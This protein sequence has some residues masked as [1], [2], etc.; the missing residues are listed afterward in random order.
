MQ[1]LCQ[2]LGAIGCG[3]QPRAGMR[4]TF[5][6]A[7]AT[8]TS[9]AQR[10]QPAG[11][12]GE[13]TRSGNSC[14]L[15]TSAPHRAIGS[16]L[17]PI[18]CATACRVPTGSTSPTAEARPRG[19]G[20]GGGPCCSASAATTYMAD[21]PSRPSAPAQKQNHRALQATVSGLFVSD[22]Q[23]SSKV[24]AALPT[25]SMIAM[26][27]SKRSCDRNGPTSPV[28]QSERE[29]HRRMLTAVRARRRGAT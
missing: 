14:H 21:P 17:V 11:W 24:S 15:L 5:R 10:W 2:R 28:V 18:V 3:P 29:A 25:E 12:P 26:A 13:N 7:V 16:L 19:S 27:S 6:P 20:T 8:W 22:E 1:P 9:C 23:V 4:R